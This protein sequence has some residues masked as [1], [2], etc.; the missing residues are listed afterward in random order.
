MR[1]FAHQSVYSAIFALKIVYSQDARTVLTEIHQN[2]RFRA[3]MCLLSR[4]PKFEL[5]TPFSIDRIMKRSCRGGTARRSKSVEILSTAARLY[6][7]ISAAAETPARRS[8][9]SVKV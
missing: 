2:T 7:Q 1:D 4:K 9:S 8:A 6:E 5:F 3:R